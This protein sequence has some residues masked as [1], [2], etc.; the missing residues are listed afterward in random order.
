MQRNL[1]P[2]LVSCCL[3]SAVRTMHEITQNG[4]DER[5]R[6]GSWIVLPGRRIS[7]QGTTEII[8][9]LECVALVNGEKH[10]EYEPLKLY[11]SIKLW[12]KEHR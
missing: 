11:S 9:D 4:H 8:W 1:R 2:K 6:V 7:K 10:F 5:F 3:S 12:I